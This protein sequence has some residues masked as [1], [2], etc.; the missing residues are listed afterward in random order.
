MQTTKKTAKRGR[1]R[2]LGHDPAQVR[3]RVR[4]SF[5]EGGFAGTSLDTLA[6]AAG[7]NRPTLYASFGDKRGMFLA[8][9]E[10]FAGEMRPRIGEALR[11]P[12]LRDA[13][14]GYYAAV[15]DRYVSGKSPRGC[16]VFCT[17]SVE[18]TQDPEIRRAVKRVL[19]ELD[20]ALTAR[21][22][23][24]LRA[25]ELGSALEPAALAQLLA[26]TQH[27]LALR[28]RAGETRAQLSS[29][30]DHAVEMACGAKPRR[31]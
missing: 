11:L 4:D 6:A 15:I 27:S 29:L 24:A 31:R 2:P 7:V 8:A 28:A 25:G 19:A 20:A 23:L 26:A 3:E 5:W 10:E 22:E 21:L 16:L 13:L 9:I 17:A 14:Q 1:G 18:A 12:N 30:A